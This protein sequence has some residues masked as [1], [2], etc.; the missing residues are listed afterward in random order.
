MARY[1]GTF[2]VASNYEP[3]VGGPF[4]ARELVDTIEDLVDPKT[5]QQANGD[6]WL[7]EG[8]AVRVKTE[9][10]IY[11]LRNPLLYFE[12]SSWIRVANYEDIESKIGILPEGKTVIDLIN[13]IEV[14][15]YDDSKIVEQINQLQ[16]TDVVLNQDLEALKSLIG[17][18]S[19][20]EQIKE[21][22]DKLANVAKTGNINDLVQTEGDYVILICGISV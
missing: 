12:I 21:A 17:T 13:E 8:I 11:L 20:K 3:L 18:T 19:V 16:E 15:K 7:Y 1:K 9:H 10:A 22:I 2:S 6:L 14:G 4:D 5:W